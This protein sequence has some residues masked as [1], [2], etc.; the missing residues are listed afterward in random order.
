MSK[1][2]L[3]RFAWAVSLMAIAAG[4][5]VGCDSKGSNDDNTPDGSEISIAASPTSLATSETSVVEAVV[6]SGSSGVQDAIV[7]F[8]VTPSTAGYFTPAYDTTNASGIAASVFTASTVG[9]AV[10]QATTD[11]G[12]IVSN[13]LSLSITTGGG[14]S[15]NGNINVTTSQSLLTANGDDSAIVT[16]VVRDD[17]GQPAADSTLVKVTA[18]EKFVDNDGNGYWSN[19]IDSLVFDANNNGRWDPMGLVPSTAWTGGGTG[20][21]SVVYVAGED[22]YTVY[23]KVTVDDGGLQASADIP[24]QLVPNTVLTSIYLSSDSI[25]LSV[26]QTGGIETG[27]IRATGYD[28]NGNSVPAGMT[29]VFV[30]LD[31]PG[32]GESLDTIGSGPDTA[33]TNSQGVATTTLHSGTISGTVRI[34]AYSG[35]VLSNATQVLIEAGPPYAIVV[36]AQKCNVA[37]WDKVGVEDSIYAIVSDVYNNPVADSTVVYFT[38]D[39]G[40][41]QSYIERTKDGKGLVASCWRSGDNDPTADGRVWYL[42]ETAGGTVRDSNMFI[43][44][45]VPNVLTLSGWNHSILADGESKFYVWVSARDLNDNFVIGGTPFKADANYLS[46]EGGEFQDGCYSSSARVKV[47]SKILKVDRSMTGTIDDGIGAVDYVT[48]WH[49]AGA[50]VTDSCLL[51]T[52]FAWG[53]GCTVGGESG[54]TPGGTIY[55]SCAINDRYGNPLGNHTV[56]WTEGVD[57]LAV[58]KTDGHGEVSGVPWTAGATEG[59]YLIVVHDTDPRGGIIMT[60]KVSVAAAE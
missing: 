38:V 21:A 5:M 22:A 39:E 45:F 37:A 47:T 17:Q 19:G 18:G 1:K 33:Y 31:G 20:T 28:I 46:V 43:N 53:G 52:D 7:H 14:T 41:I 50:S 60:H 16:I 29:I 32:G 24:I 12:D 27:T 26:R 35:T 11:D 36:G 34:R 40:T 57:T 4:V 44:S 56:V 23:L 13:T 42:V 15:G 2:L 58:S 8:V 49:S 55:L 54:T 9:S 10:V 51:L 25:G 30:I 59:D 3:F 6:T 48:Y